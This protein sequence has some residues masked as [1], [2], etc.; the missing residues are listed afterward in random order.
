MYL[1]KK[2]FIFIKFIL[3]PVQFQKEHTL[4]DYFTQISI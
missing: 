2:D 4:I 1:L 3:F